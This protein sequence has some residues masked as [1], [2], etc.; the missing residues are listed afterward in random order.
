MPSHEIFNK[1]HSIK[2]TFEDVP[3]PQNYVELAGAKGVGKTTRVWRVQTKKF[4]TI[5]PGLVSNPFGFG[6]SPDAEVISSG[7]NSKGPESVALG[8]HGNFFLWGFSASPTDM[9]PEGRDCFVNVVHYIRKFDGQKPVVRKVGAARSRDGALWSAYY[10]RQIFDEA[11]FKKS[12]PETIL[13]DRD[14]YER[15]RKS[16]LQD[17]LKRYPEEAAQALATIPS[18][19]SPGPG[20]TSNTRGSRVPTTTRFPWSTRM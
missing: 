1:P 19:T 6:D 14:R 13:K 20:R 4:P 7:L 10:L 9:T 8:R 3:T 12:L 2:L 17:T 18:R 16:S 5:D 15:Y 11:A